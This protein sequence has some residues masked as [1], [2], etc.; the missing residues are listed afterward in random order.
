MGTN[1]AVDAGIVALHAFHSFNGEP[2]IGI[3]AYK[4]VVIAVADHGEIVPQHLLD[5]GVFVP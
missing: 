5:H 3:R 4:H 2:I 1:G